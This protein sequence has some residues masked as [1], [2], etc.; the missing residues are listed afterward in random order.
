MPSIS[1]ITG[2]NRAVVQHQAAQANLQGCSLES[3][4]CARSY[5]SRPI[6]LPNCTA[7]IDIEDGNRAQPGG[8]RGCDARRRTWLL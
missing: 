2:A 4:K 6:I 1:L 3:V 5:G 7:A 8:E